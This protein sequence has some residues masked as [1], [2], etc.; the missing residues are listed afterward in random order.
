ML[1]DVRFESVQGTRKRGSAFEQHI[2]QIMVNQSGGSSSIDLV[3]V[4]SFFGISGCIL[5]HIQVAKL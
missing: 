3:L 4:F 1:D 2:H 5:P